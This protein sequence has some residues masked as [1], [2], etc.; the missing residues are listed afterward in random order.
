M[1]NTNTTNF[2]VWITALNENNSPFEFLERIVA[3]NR[4]QAEAKALD[5]Y[6]WAQSAKAV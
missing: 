4:Y 1:I 3:K 5:Q 6:R 2:W